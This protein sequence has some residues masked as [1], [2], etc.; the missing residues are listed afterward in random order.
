MNIVPAG[1][2]IPRS[3]RMGFSGKERDLFDI[4]LRGSLLQIPTFGFYRFWLNTDVRR[5]LWTHTRIGPDGRWSR[6][7]LTV[8]SP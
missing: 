3:Q 6:Y 5:H 4:L 2:Q 1:G 8:R 7:G